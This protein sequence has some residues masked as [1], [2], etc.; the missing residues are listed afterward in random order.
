MNIGEQL[1]AALTVYGLPILAVVVFVGSL[2]LPLPLALVLIAS[3]SFAAEGQ[4]RFWTVVLAAGAAAVAGDVCGYAIGR[5]GGDHAMRRLKS[6]PKLRE[7]LERAEQTARK[8]GAIGIFMSRWLI[9]PAAP[10]INLLSGASRYP[11]PQFILWDVLGEALWVILYVSLGRLIAG[12]VQAI[13]ALA[14]DITW[15]LLALAVAGVLVW[16]ILRAGIFNNAKR[17]EQEP[18]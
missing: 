17:R 1:L 12:R 11:L 14:S 16:R 7:R 8:W 9:T 6:R 5:W 4:M 2:G 18:A 15:V 3:G 10:W 13:S